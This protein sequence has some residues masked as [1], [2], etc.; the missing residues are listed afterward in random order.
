[1]RKR[2]KPLICVLLGGFLFVV[3]A[4]YAT[5]VHNS[6]EFIEP[7]GLCIKYKRLNNQ[8]TNGA[9]V[10]GRI[11]ADKELNQKSGINFYPADE[12]VLWIK[13]KDG[14][15]DAL[16]LDKSAT[17]PNS[18]FSTEDFSYKPWRVKVG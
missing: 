12:Y 8:W 14:S 7:L 16:K 3:T 18:I 10:Y 13:W 15:V 17:F 11:Y 2:V 9:K 5:A 1:M 4:A 6:V